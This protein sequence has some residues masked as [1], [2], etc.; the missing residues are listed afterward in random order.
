MLSTTSTTRIGRFGLRDVIHAARRQ[1]DREESAARLRY[2][3]GCPVSPQRFPATL[4]LLLTFILPCL[5]AGEDPMLIHPDQIARCLKLPLA[6]NLEVTLARNPYYLRGDFDGDGKIDYAVAVRGRKTKRNGV[7]V[8]GG[9]GRTFVLGADQPLRPPFSDM[10]ND[11]F[12]APNWAVYSKAEVGALK[13]FAGVNVPVIPANL[14]GEPL[15]MI[16][17]D[18]IALIYWNGREFKWAPPGP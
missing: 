6:A 15:A 12:V 2:A 8:C 10:P 7:P 1:R 4:L 17:E 18:G 3:T 5:A 16:W 9:S 13:A 11:N 14:M